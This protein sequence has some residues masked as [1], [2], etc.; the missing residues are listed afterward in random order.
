VKTAEVAIEHI[1][2]GLL[3]LA[4]FGL[5]LLSGLCLDW[6]F[7]QREVLIGVLGLAYLFGIVFDKLTDT[8]L[9][10][11]EQWLRLKR[12][13]EH[14]KTNTPGY[15][16]DPFPQDALEFS[17]RGKP[18]G[19]LEWMDSLRSRI[20]TSRGLAVLGFPA[21]LG[22]AVFQQCLQDDGMAHAYTLV[23]AN[24]FFIV[25]SLWIAERFKLP[26]TTTLVKDANKRA[27]QMHEGRTHMR[28][29]IAWF[30]ILLIPSVMV[31]ADGAWRTAHVESV[32]IGAGGAVACLLGL[33][34]WHRITST[35]LAFIARKLPELLETDAASAQSGAGATRR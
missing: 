11:L 35:Y 33:W 5:P 31:T 25:G 14:L 29:A 15:R 12:A 1:L 23:V 24:L 6:K 10:P 30:A 8:V 2:A 13:D 9:S 16:G 17:L 28:R 7:P 26:R 3:A 22:M 32:V 27:G 34:S 19:R 4:A 18:D 21:A 20:R